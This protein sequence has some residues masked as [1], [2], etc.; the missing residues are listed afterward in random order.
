MAPPSSC[1]GSFRSLLVWGLTWGLGRRTVLGTAHLCQITVL[2]CWRQFPIKWEGDGED[3][4][5]KSGQKEPSSTLGGVRGAG[6]GGA[7]GL[8]RVAAPLTLSC[9]H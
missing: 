1:E 7:W 4:G 2:S 9:W 6:A 5:K 8:L 3:S